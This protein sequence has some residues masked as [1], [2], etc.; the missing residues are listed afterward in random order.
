MTYIAQLP[1]Y[2]A[3]M[4]GRFRPDI[5]V[6]HVLDQDA[7][8]ASYELNDYKAEKVSPHRADA[9]NELMQQIHDDI[10]DQKLTWS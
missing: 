4:E 3:F 2:E 6:E 10:R 1:F 9:V 7:W 8:R 5:A